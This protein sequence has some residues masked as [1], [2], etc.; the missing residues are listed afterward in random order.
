MGQLLVDSVLA[1]DYP[2]MLGIVLVMSFAKSI[3]HIIADIL[4]YLADP[5]IRFS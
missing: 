4:Y 5:R 2:V 3:A 1:R